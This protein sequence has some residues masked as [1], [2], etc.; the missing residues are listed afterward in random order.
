MLLKL[1]YATEIAQSL[2]PLLLEDINLSSGDV[3]LDVARVSHQGFREGPQGAL[4]VIDS[5]ICD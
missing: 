5:P 4:I 3:G 1:D 2:F